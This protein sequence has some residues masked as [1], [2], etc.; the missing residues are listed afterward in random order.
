MYFLG[1]SVIKIITT[2]L[3]QLHLVEL[4]LYFTPTRKLFYWSQKN[5]NAEFLYDL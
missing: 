2:I 3:S 1:K 5:Q 4:A